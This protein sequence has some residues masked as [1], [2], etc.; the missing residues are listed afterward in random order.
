MPK[1]QKG[2]PTPARQIC[3]RSAEP[4]GETANAQCRCRV[5]VSLDGVGRSQPRRRRALVGAVAV[6]RAWRRRGPG[7]GTDRGSRRPELPS[8]GRSGSGPAG[9]HRAFP[10]R[11]R[12]D[13]AR[14]RRLGSHSLGPVL[15]VA[16]PPRPRE[17]AQTPGGIGRDPSAQHHHHH[18]RP[19]VPQAP[20]NSGGRC[21]AACRAVVGGAPA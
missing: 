17:A 7:V 3:T 6:L 13:R 20:E 8:Q 21:R 5:P 2:H 16:L 10:C 15:A 12:R 18:S 4:L 19:Q 1:L 11:R 9:T 14:R